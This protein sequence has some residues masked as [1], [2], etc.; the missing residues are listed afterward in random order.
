MSGSCTAAKSPMAEF[1]KS[2][3]PQELWKAALKPQDPLKPEHPAKPPSPLDPASAS[4]PLRAAPAPGTG[5]L[6]DVS[7]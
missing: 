4:A 6:L 1:L 5:L 3:T 7:A 2:Q